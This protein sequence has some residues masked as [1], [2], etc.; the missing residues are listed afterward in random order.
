MRNLILLTLSILSYGCVQAKVSATIP[1]GKT[2]ILLTDSAE[3]ARILSK[4]DNYTAGFSTFDKQGRLQMTTALTEDDY[5]QNVARES[6]T[7]TTAE[8]K[9]L[10][11]CFE[12]IES[13]CKLNKVVLNLPKTIVVAK[14]TGKEELGSQGYTRGNTIV[15]ASSTE[16]NLVAHELFHV[17]SRFNPK[18][19][20]ELYRIIHF[21]KCNPIAY[22]AAFQNLILTNPDCPIVEHYAEVPAS[23]FGKAGDKVPATLVLYSSENYSGGDVFGKYLK[24]GLLELE[25]VGKEMKPK[26]DGGRTS[27]VE[28]GE[29]NM[30]DV[31]NYLGANT[32][33]LLHPEEISA[34]H[35]SMMIGGQ[36]VGNPSAIQNMKEVL[37][38]ESKS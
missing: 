38:R 13:W 22:H 25:K 18:V 10:A 8:Q 23:F 27:F 1:F 11:N 4:S 33:Y 29:K 19:R 37:Q 31:I 34:E 32:G 5:L 28:L 17:Y 2:K 6:R 3:T 12:K 15:L 24:V 21:E 30:M 16:V 7:W 20:D 14:T 26:M 35:F 9:A 36:K